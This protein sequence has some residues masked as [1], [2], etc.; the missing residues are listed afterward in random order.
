[1]LTM[2][3]VHA[4]RLRAKLVVL[5]CCHIGRGREVKSEDAVGIARA[6]LCAGARQFWCHSGELMMRQLCCTFMRSFYQ[7]LADGERSS[8]ALHHAMKSLRES[9]QYSAIKHW[10]PFVLIGDDV[11]FEFGQEKLKQKGK[12]CSQLCCGFDIIPCVL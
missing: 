6:F 9:K 12:F 4:V 5:S 2:S 11:T 7:R 1:M 3:D 8:L 10:A